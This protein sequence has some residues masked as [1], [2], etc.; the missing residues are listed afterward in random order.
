MPRVS[1]SGKPVDA[2]VIG[3]G[4]AGCTPAYE[5]ASRNLN[6]VVLEQAAIASESSGRNTGT[7]LSGPQ[8]EVVELLDACVEIYSE[9]SRGPIPFEFARIGHLLISEDEASFAGARAVAERYRAVGVGMEQVS[10][11][12]L[13]REYPKV[14]FNVAGGGRMP[15]ASAKTLRPAQL[16]RLAAAALA[17]ILIASFAPA[18][19]AAAEIRWEVYNRFRYYKDP[20]IFRSYLATATTKPLEP[21]MAD[22]ILETE[23]KLQSEADRDGWAARNLGKESLYWNRGTL[24]YDLCGGEAEYV[25]PKSHQILAEV[26]DEAGLANATCAWTLDG[27]P[28]PQASP[29]RSCADARIEVPYAPDDAKPHRL[30]VTVTDAEAGGAPTM[31]TQDIVVRDYLIAGMGDSFA[32]GVGNPDRPAQLDPSGKSAIDYLNHSPYLPVRPGVSVNFFGA[33]SS[34]P[35]TAAAAPEW[36]DARCF[37]S[38]YGPEFR[39]ALHLAVAMPHDA[40]TFLDFAC[41]GARVLEGLLSRKML[42]PGF[43]PSVAPVSAQVDAVAGLVCAKRP[44]A[45]DRRI[46]FG[47]YNAK[48]CSAADAICE[49]PDKNFLN[50]PTLTQIRLTGCGAEDARRPIDYVLLGIGGNDIGAAALIAQ[51]ALRDDTIDSVALRYLFTRHLG[52]TENGR[53]ASLRLRY[54][55]NKYHHLSQAFATLL[56][57]R[58]DGST[59]PQSRVLLLGYPLADSSENG[60]VCGADAATSDQADKSVDGLNMFGAFLD[61]ALG[62]PDKTGIVADVHRA[63]CDLDLARAGWLKG[64][65]D[66]HGAKIRLEELLKS[67]C[68]PPAA[69]YPASEILPWSYVA[70]FVETSTRHGYCATW[71]Q[72]ECRKDPSSPAC[73]AETLEMPYFSPQI[74]PGPTQPYDVAKLRP[75][76]SRTRWLRSFNDAYLGANWQESLANLN[77]MDNALSAF[78]T[79]ALHPTAE[80]SAAM[81]DSLF[82]ALANDLCQRKEISNGAESGEFELCGAKN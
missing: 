29:A 48:D 60:V 26:S 22:W 30:A 47:S 75:Y 78:T 34:G 70:G 2:V 77:T 59:D 55:A 19:L 81:A 44:N 17:V 43:A 31:L 72:R 57:I 67:T 11:K 71:E 21:G 8:T 63:L 35:Q 73:V 51:V 15:M 10:G 65:L 7:L 56:P 1:T 6:V 9:L 76:A 16:R 20:E 49:F 41:S 4:I 36:L 61:S 68:A 45:F 3:G 5:L 13:A 79:S 62:S 25:T 52:E 39:A 58:A 64:S 50:D 46:V 33:A 24:K 12:N 42:D 82:R 37:R 23:H 38:Q 28:A 32:A 54:L 69:A 74:G 80:A 40:V 27:E 66:P 14:G 18:A 53:I